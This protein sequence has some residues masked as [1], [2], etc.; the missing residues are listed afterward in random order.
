M[1]ESLLKDRGSMKEAAIVAIM[2]PCVH[3][4]MHLLGRG[5]DAFSWWQA[6]IAGPVVG[7]FYWMFLSGFR[8][9]AAEDVTP[10]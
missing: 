2:F 8:R 4:G 10:R 3:F 9:F 6:L 1:K 5:S 7:F